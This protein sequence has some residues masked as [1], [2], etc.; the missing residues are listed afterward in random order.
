MAMMRWR[1]RMRGLRTRARGIRV[2]GLV[3]P[4]TVLF[5]LPPERAAA[6]TAAGE[7]IYRE[8]CM[9]CHGRRGEA[10][11][12]GRSKPLA[13]LEESVIRDRLAAARAGAAPKTMQD[14]IKAALTPEEAEALVGFLGTLR[15]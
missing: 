3:V 9:T 5:L 8:R 1:G 2:L 12:L 11:A 15:R 4:V 7:A 10:R 14:R 13:G 6:Q